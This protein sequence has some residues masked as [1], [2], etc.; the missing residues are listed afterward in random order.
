[1]EEAIMKLRHGSLRQ[2]GF[3]L[4]L[5]AVYCAALLISPR[6]AQ[7]QETTGAVTGTVTDPS[8]AA[9]PNASVTATNVQM[10]TT[11]PT[12][13]NSAGVYNLPRLPIGQYRLKVEAKGFKT[14]VRPAFE[15]QMNQVARVDLK[16]TVG[17]LTQTVTVSAAPPLLHTETM[18]VGLVTSANFNVN[19]P[20]ATNN[21]IQLTLLT[22][23]AT[24]VDPSSF[25]NGQ[26]TGGGGRP[27][28]NGNREEGNNFLLD[29]IDNNQISDN[30]T[31]Y[32]PSVDAIQEFDVITNNAPAQYGQFQGGAISV[33]LKSGTDQYHG[34]AFEFLRNSGLNA[35]DWANNWQGIPRPGLRWNTFGATFG[36]P[37]PIAKHK[38]FFFADYEGLRLDSPPAIAAYSVMTAAERSGDFSQLL[39]LSSPRQLYNPCASFSGPCTAPA[40]PAASR[41]PFVNDIIPS[42]MID[43]VASKLFSSGDYPLPTLPGNTSG[44]LDNAL[45]TSHTETSTNQGDL[46]LDYMVNSKNH[47]WGSYSDSFQQIPATNSVLVM[48]QSFNNSPFHAGVIDWT[49]TFSPSVLMDAKMGLNRIYLIDG[50]QVT[51]LGNFA[52]TLGIADGNVHG[53]GL[54]GI[55]F[56][57]NIG[58]G[59]C[60]TDGYASAIGA[61]N[62]EELFA[63][64]TWEP[65]VDILWTHGLHSFHFGFQAMRHDIN[66]YYAGNNGEYGY[67]G[68]S[69]IYTDGPNPA[70]PVSAGFPE[71]DFFLGLPESVGL[72]ISGG[73]WGQR[74]WVLAP[75]VQ[76]DWRATSNLT[77][78]LGLRWQYNQPWHEV[79]N[80]Q[81][82]FG[83]ISGTEYIAGTSS[84]PYSDCSALYNEDYHDWE[85]RVGFAYALG[86]NNVVRGAYTISSFLEGTGTNLRLPL[87]PPFQEET[88]ANYNTGNLTYFPATNTQQ[89]FSTLA[90]P[91]NPDAGALIRLWDPNVQPAMVQQW[92]FSIEHQFPGQMLLSVGY[93]GQHGTHLMIPMP[94]LQLRLPGEAGCPSTVT[95]PCNSP[96]LSGNPTLPSEISQISGTASIANQ[97]YNAL[98]A[99]LTKHLTQGLEFQLSYAYQKGMTN[100]IGYYGQGGQASSNSAYPQN[101]YN[102]ASEWGPT[103]FNDTNDFTASYTYML[104]FGSGQ[105]FGRSMG[106]TAN[107]I[108]G[109]WQLTGIVTLHSGFPMTVFGTDL[110]GTNSRGFRANQ[111]GPNTYPQGVGPDTTWFG[112]SAYAQP[113]AGTFGDAANGTVIGPGETDWDAG[114]QKEFPISESK[115]LEFRAE[116]INFTNTPIFASPGNMTVD[117]SQFGDILSDDGYQRT[118]QFALKLYF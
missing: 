54:P 43:P 14:E 41:M 24:T 20:L 22:P 78:N 23:G 47:L 60:S 52:D 86:K 116:F 27:Y 59:D 117:T 84:C 104:P 94:Y 3:Y 101:L 7:G 115:R 82:N 18:Q 89:G 79:Y 71:A 1:M 34:D 46:K 109:N 8:G 93:I 33:T 112:T 97:T 64:T 61:P 29:G 55:C 5:S 50:S 107:Y 10:G 77:L 42:S 36:G 85:P 87:N 9:I 106:R 108:L 80:R 49:H 111:I 15:L 98:Q 37:V 67:L 48:G 16:L 51:G 21:F 88:A 72:G 35:N 90:S 53:A 4:G 75:Y 92:N 32:Q 83:M 17:A 95:A 44:F 113:A 57:N 31:S 70:S 96:F 110:S 45:N 99:S 13:T 68:Y 100:A 74:Q 91:T 81:A 69:G 2:L 26:R 25:T 11:W 102:I 66:V 6:T 12:Q 63:D 40:N 76:D 19:L 114:F 73:T 28:I 58:G 30:L 56:N 39:S 118:I 38:L 65:T 103:Y 62:N 105:R